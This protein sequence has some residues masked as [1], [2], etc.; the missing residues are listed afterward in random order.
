MTAA[1]QEVSRPLKIAAVLLRSAFLIALVVLVVRVSLPQNE[2]IWTV[3]DTLG[4]VV[5]LLLGLL[6]IVWILYHL[7]RLPKDAQGYRPHLDISRTSIG[8]ADTRGAFCFLVM[9]A[10]MRWPANRISAR[11]GCH[12]QSSADD[13]GMKIATI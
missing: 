12:V 3:Y 1:E 8:S 13:Y 4:D 6:V 5:R 11:G 2:S 7:F 10:S 9:R